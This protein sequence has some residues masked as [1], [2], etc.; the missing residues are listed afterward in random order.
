MIGF[1]RQVASYFS[2]EI[3]NLQL[4]AH[5]QARYICQRVSCAPLQFQAP[6]HTDL[7]QVLPRAKAH[8]FS[9]PGE[10]DFATA[11]AVGGAEVTA[12][13]TAQGK[14]HNVS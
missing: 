2:K 13:G 6:D 8:A 7:E 9:V 4:F 12:L 10:S 1:L 14:V 11:V 5:F 3:L